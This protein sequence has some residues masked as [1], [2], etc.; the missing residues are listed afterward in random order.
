[1]VQDLWD[2]AS[3][4]RWLRRG[5]AAMGQSCCATQ[6]PVSE[7]R[8]A[9][10]MVLW[11][12]AHP[13]MDL[14]LTF[15]LATSRRLCTHAGLAVTGSYAHLYAVRMPTCFVLARIRARQKSGGKVSKHRCPC[16]AAVRPR[17]LGRV[18]RRMIR[19]HCSREMCMDVTPIPDTSCTIPD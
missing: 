10:L 12:R 15:G 3:R 19:G 17:K 14:L 11:C 4:L 8:A 13:W 5:G 18:R 1:M 2:T 9:L 7:C 6:S 16:L